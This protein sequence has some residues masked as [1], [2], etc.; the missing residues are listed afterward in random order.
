[1]RP[2]ERRLGVWLRLWAP[3][4]AVG[5]AL[6]YLAPGPVTKNLNAGARMTGLAESPIDADN[7]WIVLAASYMVLITGLAQAAA[8]E[9][10]RRQDLV[11]FLALGKAASSLGALGYFFGRRRSYAFLVNFLLDGSICAGTLTLL[12]AAQ[13]EAAASA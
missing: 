3:A 9:P 7:L 5:G 11:R 12:K 8:A 1:M 6:F 13:R 10:L 2:A 4:F